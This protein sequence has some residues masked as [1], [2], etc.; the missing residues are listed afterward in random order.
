MFIF[1]EQTMEKTV[2]SLLSYSVT[3]VSVQVEAACAPEAA[4]ERQ[5]RQRP[6]VPVSLLRQALQ[7]QR[8]ADAT[9]D[10]TRRGQQD[11]HLPGVWEG[12]HLGRLP[13]GAFGE[14]SLG[15]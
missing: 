13:A 8:H 1:K 6:P 4:R 3:A 11:L 15:V 7:A 14:Y 12:V 5:A 9:Q 2:K 10:H